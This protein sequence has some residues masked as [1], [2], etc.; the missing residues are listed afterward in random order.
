MTAYPVSSR[1]LR[2][3]RGFPLESNHT[4]RKDCAYVRGE[5]RIISAVLDGKASL[6]DF[7]RGKVGIDDILSH[8]I[9]SRVPVEKII[10]PFL[11]PDV[12][13]FMLGENTLHPNQASFRSYVLSKYKD[14]FPEA[15]LMTMSDLS[16]MTKDTWDV[17]RRCVEEI[18]SER[19]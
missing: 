11:L 7:F 13:L 15:D 16:R 8:R 14:L 17:T 2:F 1:E 3:F 6:K 5:G 12:I 4:Q 19:N 10:L 9:D 18:R